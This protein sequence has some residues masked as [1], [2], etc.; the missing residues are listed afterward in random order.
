MVTKLPVLKVTKKTYHDSFVR[1]QHQPG[2]LLHKQYGVV[3]INAWLESVH[4]SHQLLI[5]P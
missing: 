1:Q 4:C 3:Q 5:S 2:H